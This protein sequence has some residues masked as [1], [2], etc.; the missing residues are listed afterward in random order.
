MGKDPYHNKPKPPR[1]IG[2][3]PRYLKEVT[4]GFF[5]RLAYIVGMVWRTGP[6]ILIVMTLTAIFSGIMPIVGSLLSKEILNELQNVI[7]Q[8]VASQVSGVNT[9]VVFWGSM[10]MFLLIFYFL[11]RI[12][13]QVVNRVSAAVT[14]IAG[15]KVV[16]Y[17]RVQI[18]QKAK[19]LDLA[20]FDRSYEILTEVLENC[21]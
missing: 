5:S 10:V 3:L 20:S 13:N 17:V 14:R 16:R 12:L 11:Y 9:G 6:W 7:A 4:G 15:E 2:D 19:E 8:Q 18:M 1:G 21:R